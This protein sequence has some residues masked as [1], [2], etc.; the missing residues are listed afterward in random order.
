MCYR[1]D[2]GCQGEARFER[3]GRG[4]GYGPPPWAGRGWETGPGFGWPFGGPT[5]AERKESLEAF[6]KHLEERLA[7]V[8]DELG[9]L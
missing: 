6:K 9:K 3:H 1:C 8:N 4:R 5:K 7:D 2:C